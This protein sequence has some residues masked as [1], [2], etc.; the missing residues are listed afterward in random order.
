MLLFLRSWRNCRNPS[1]IHV[2]YMQ[3]YRTHVFLKFLWSWGAD[4]TG[5]RDT[6]VE[7]YHQLWTSGYEHIFPCIAYPY[8]WQKDSP[9]HLSPRYNAVL[10]PYLRRRQLNSP[11]LLSI[12]IRTV[13]TRTL[14]PSLPPCLLHT[15][16]FSNVQLLE[17]TLYSTPKASGAHTPDWLWM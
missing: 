6:K 1:C 17:R 13:R 7:L 8:M 10:V 14:N 15:I 3:M 16:V 4:Q 12:V 5:I 11:A 2:A 9:W